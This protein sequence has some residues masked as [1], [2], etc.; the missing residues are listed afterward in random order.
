M[1]KL[2]PLLPTLKEKKRY[3]VYEVLSKSKLEEDLSIE[4]VK[5][6][7]SLLGI[8]D[9]AKAGIQSIEYDIAKHKGILR[10]TVKEVDKLKISLALIN[11]LND[12][13]IMIRTIGASGILKKARSKYMA[14]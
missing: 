5:K 1:V 12:K 14:S 8:F 2:K 4:I 6:V 13:E 7:T 10:V 11:K 3:L 9:S